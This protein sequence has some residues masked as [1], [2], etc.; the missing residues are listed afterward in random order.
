MIRALGLKRFAGTAGVPPAREGEARKWFVESLHRDCVP[1]GRCG[2][3]A[4]GPSKSLDRF[5]QANDARSEADLIHQLLIPL[6][7]R[8][9]N[10][11]RFAQLRPPRQALGR[12]PR[13]G[14]PPQ[15]R[16]QAR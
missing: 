15:F 13:G 9:R 2:R 8:G 6:R 16:N 11:D 1:A 12:G 7:D 4:R 14:G 3:D 5:S 10:T